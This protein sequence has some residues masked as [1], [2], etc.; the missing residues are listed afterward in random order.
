MSHTIEGGACYSRELP[1]W[2]V[3]KRFEN[4]KETRLPEIGFTGTD[5]SECE[6]F[7]AAIQEFAFSKGW[8]EDHHWKLRFATSHLKGKALRWYVRLD[9]SIKKDWDLFVQALFDQYPAAEDP[10]NDGKVTPVW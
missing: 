6:A 8:D 9:P 5:G 7:V 10:E 2:Q 4:F 1:S 3:T